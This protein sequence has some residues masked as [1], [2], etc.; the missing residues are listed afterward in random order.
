MGTHVPPGMTATE[1][2]LEQVTNK[3]AR[4]RARK[5]YERDLRERLELQ[6]GVEAQAAWE[7]TFAS[8]KEACELSRQHCVEQARREAAIEK[9]K[10][11]AYAAWDAEYA[12]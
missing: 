9:A 11:A 12:E 6:A 1:A 4:I 10:L 2:A 8:T 3:G 5:R 7:K